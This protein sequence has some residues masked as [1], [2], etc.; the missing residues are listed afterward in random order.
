VVHTAQVRNVLVD[1][2]AAP[3]WFSRQKVRAWSVVTCLSVAH[4]V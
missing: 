3:E 1:L 4:S 2:D